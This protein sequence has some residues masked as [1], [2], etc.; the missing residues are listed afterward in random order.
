MTTPPIVEIDG[1]PLPETVEWEDLLGPDPVS[2]NPPITPATPA[3]APVKPVQPKP[4]AWNCINP[5]LM[6]LLKLNAENKTTRAMVLAVTGLD[7][8]AD[9][10]TFEQVKA[11]LEWQKP[12]TAPS[13]VGRS[14]PVSVQFLG[15]ENGRAYYT[16]NVAYNEIIEL[17]IDRIGELAERSENYNRLLVNI[18]TE[19]RN[20]LDTEAFSHM[21]RQPAGDNWSFDLDGD[22]ERDYNNIRAIYDMERVKVYVNEALRQFFPIDY[23]RLIGPL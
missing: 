7:L 18:Q 9:A 19:F 20:E 10:K 2:S 21:A 22:N 12:L 23:A 1:P 8:P 14:L 13:Q 15:S 4:N 6:G 5:G 11:W 16:A 17:T 3:P